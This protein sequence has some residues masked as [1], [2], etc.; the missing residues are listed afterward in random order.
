MAAKLRMRLR[1]G[2]PARFRFIRIILFLMI[3][4]FVIHGY[5]SFRLFEWDILMRKASITY[6]SY[7][8]NYVALMTVLLITLVWML[9]YGFGALSRME[10]ILEQIIQGNYAFRM[11]LRQRDIMR[12]FAEKL[13]K[14]LDQLEECKKRDAGK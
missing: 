11:H 3:V 5:L 14:I 13:N 12:P 7:Q 2:V 1:L 6:V 4:S 9:H 8:L 10:N